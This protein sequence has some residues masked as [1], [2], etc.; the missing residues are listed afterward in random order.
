MK[1]IAFLLC[2][3]FAQHVYAGDRDNQMVLDKLHQQ[4]FFGC[5]KA[6]VSMGIIHKGTQ[7]VEARLV[8]EGLYKVGDTGRVAVENRPNRD[9]ASSVDIDISSVDGG[10]S[11]LY[12]YSIRKIDNM[13]FGWRGGGFA[14][15]EISCNQVLAQ[16]SEKVIDQTGS[17]VWQR[18]VY[19]EN[20]ESDRILVNNGG[21]GCI[22][23]TRS[24]G[25]V[26]SGLGEEM[27]PVK[28]GQ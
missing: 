4:G 11:D 25:T 15:L 16:P 23:V 7:R 14:Q 9:K 26:N 6:I 27:D 18:N 3:L 10:Y 12:S 1:R 20:R 21:R 28:Q 19:E 24:G 13:C 5:D 22:V 17:I 8:N 2:M